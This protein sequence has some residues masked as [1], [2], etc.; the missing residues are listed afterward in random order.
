[1]PFRYT[2][3]LI[4]TSLF[5]AST[6]LAQPKV[7][8]RTERVPRV[9]QISETARTNIMGLTRLT[10]ADT[11]LGSPV[12]T[13]THIITG[14][15]IGNELYK[16]YI[17]PT[18][19]GCSYPYTITEIN[20][21]MY[22]GPGSSGAAFS[23]SVDIETVDSITIPGCNVPG[24][25]IAL[26]V[27][28]DVTIPAE[29]GFYDIWIPL[30]T[31]VTVTGPF[32]A[33]FFLGAPID[34][35]ALAAVVVDSTHTEH[36]VSFNIWDPE[37]GFIDLLDNDFWNFPGV[38]VLYVS[39][40]SG[41][42]SN[43][44]QPL[45]SMIN[46]TE[47]GL[48]YGVGELWAM[49][50]SGSSI[51]EY[52]SF[53]YSDGGPWIE[54]AK[55]FDG[56]RPLRDGVASTYLGAGFST[57]WNPIGLPEGNY[58][59]RA[60]M[61]D[62]LGRKSQHQVSVYVE[63]TPPIPRIISPGEFADFCSPL[64]LIMI[65][66]D[67]NISSVQVEWQ[68]LADDYSVGLTTLFQNDLGDSNG[69][70]DD[71]NRASAGEFGDYYNGP[72]AAALAAQVW[73]NRGY[74]DIMKDGLD[75]LSVGELAE[76]L[77]ASFL[78]R[79]NNGTYDEELFHGL[80]E[81]FSS[82]GDDL[83]FEY[84][85][86]PDYITLRKWVEGDERTVI[87]SA[88]GETG[89]WLALDGFKGWLTDDIATIT[90]SV[91]MT[92]TMMDIPFRATFGFNEIQLN[93]E[94]H[95]VDMAVSMMGRN[96]EVDRA[97]VG[98]DFV[99]ADGWS[100]TWLPMDLVEDSR[101]FFRAWTQDAT[102]YEGTSGTILQFNC[103]QIFLPGDYTDDGS[104]DIIDLMLLIDFIAKAGPAP[105]GGAGRADANCDNLINAADII[106]FMNYLYGHNDDPCH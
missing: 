37:I 59:I 39:G 27:D 97:V 72:V 52:V 71:S 86:N 42:A 105:E 36:C 88:N 9:E 43:E 75:D 94:W 51:I 45:V 93:G 11:C 77:A 79:E 92:G 74:T 20:M 89:F 70:P 82:H 102:G 50:R 31:P 54:I 100:L 33:G 56:S 78:T 16:N 6:S 81:Y 104:V 63:P 21:P 64:E 15:L 84:E 90:V 22:F 67:E 69:N 87:I 83:I 35:A 19:S 98:I 13:I 40:Y 68:T 5:I 76:N 91:P 1:M 95:L 85:R 65:C 48:V 14:W 103:S 58:T 46:P 47:G 80:T 60:T 106:Y 17:D 44:P 57:T 3:I 26:S 101:Y 25:M 53:E 99:G 4:L 96:W 32:F 30:D 10:T 24:D 34:A 55:D 49:D 23:V 38:L 61:V 41:S 8:S 28:W 66:S 29:E 7:Q 18:V 62:T 73:F 12:D 2:V